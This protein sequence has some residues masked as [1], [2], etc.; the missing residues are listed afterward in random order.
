MGTRCTQRAPVMDEH[1]GNEKKPNTDSFINP[2]CV[3]QPPPPSPPVAGLNSFS[4][5]GKDRQTPCPGRGQQGPSRR[6]DAVAAGQAG[7]LR[8]RAGPLSPVKG[9]NGG[10]AVTCDVTQRPLRRLRHRT[11]MQDTQDPVTGSTADLHGDVRGHSDTRT[12]PLLPLHALRPWPSPA[13]PPAC[14]H[15]SS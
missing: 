13:L 6:R 12:Q 11:D 5:Q 3:M 2:G 8:G 15:S 14:P 10:E 9:Q 7:S 1:G 4:V